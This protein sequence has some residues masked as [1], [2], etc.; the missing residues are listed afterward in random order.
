MRE[1]IEE[2]SDSDCKRF[3]Y[4]QFFVRKPVSREM[5]LTNLGKDKEG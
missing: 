2:K 1:V 5:I 3:M 4:V